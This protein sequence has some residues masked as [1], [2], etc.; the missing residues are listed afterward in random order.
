MQVRATLAA[1]AASFALAI[2]CTPKAR[3]TT[4]D[5]GVA[6]NETWVALEQYGTKIK[7]PRGWE[8]ARKEAIVAGVAKDARGAWIIAGTKT[9]A[10]A[11]EKLALGLR[12][13]KIELGEVTDPQREVVVHGIPFARQDFRSAAVEGKPAFVVVLAGDSLPG[14]QGILVFIGYALVGDDAAKDEL[15]EAISSVS[16]S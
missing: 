13:M 6:S 2:A 9:K 12:E 15:T 10:E 14:G 16:P 3:P 4:A 7:V 5:R 8:F 11:K 1:V